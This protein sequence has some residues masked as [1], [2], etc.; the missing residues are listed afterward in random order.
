MSKYIEY[1][2]KECSVCKKQFEFVKF[3]D[4]IEPD[5]CMSAECLKKK[6]LKDIR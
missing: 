2:I 6:Y 3:L 1:S 4:G 5:T